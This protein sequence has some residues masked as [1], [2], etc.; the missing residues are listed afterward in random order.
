MLAQTSD[1]LTRVA[2][3]KAHAAVWQQTL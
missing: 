1:R 3:T 2:A